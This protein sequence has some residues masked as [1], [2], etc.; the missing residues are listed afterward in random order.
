MEDQ[1]LYENEQNTETQ[2]TN[3]KNVL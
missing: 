3:A 1:E 2:I